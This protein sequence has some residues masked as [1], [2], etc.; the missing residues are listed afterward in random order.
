MINLGLMDVDTTSADHAA[1]VAAVNTAISGRTDLAFDGTTLTFTGDGNPMPSIN[2]NL[3]ATE[4]A[5]VEGPEDYTVAISAPSTTTGSDIA[6]GTTSVTTTIVDN[7]TAIWNL[8][9]TCLLYT[10]PS[11][12]DQR[13]SRMPSSA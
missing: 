4:D 5:F 9:G 7:D 13:G 6:I 2:I 12:R 11:P 1:F 10:S 3:A 8:V